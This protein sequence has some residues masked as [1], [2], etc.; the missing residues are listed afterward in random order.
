MGRHHG[1]CRCS[2]CSG[3]LVVDSSAKK[4]QH[5]TGG[6][7][8]QLL[9]R[10]GSHVQGGD[11]VI[12]LDPTTTQANLAIVMNGLNQFVSTPH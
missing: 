5:L 4:V 6:I 12:R 7:V 11:V 10:D 9:V 1:Y 2:D 3:S 8:G